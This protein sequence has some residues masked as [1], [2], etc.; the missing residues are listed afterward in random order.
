MN[1]DAPAR[2]AGFLAA[3]LPLGCAVAVE[4][5]VEGTVPVKPEVEHSLGRTALRRALAM[6]ADRG[7]CAV[8]ATAIPAAPNGA[9]ALPAGF[10]GSI[11]HS[12]GLAVAIAATAMAGTS[13]L[14][15]GVDVEVG[16]FRE[17]LLKFV[18]NDRELRALSPIRREQGVTARAAF[19]AKEAA[20]KAFSSNQ[21]WAV[22]RL[23][24][25]ELTEFCGSSSPSG[26]PFRA[27]AAGAGLQ[28][29]ICGTDMGWGAVAWA[30]LHNDLGSVGPV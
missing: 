21:P 2:A 9:P 14:S 16:D 17:D 27:V 19:S 18:F 13:L 20:F 11:S 5:K 26:R 6:V 4:G 1:S 23:G 8:N 30:V 7:N 29:E 3:T 10:I 24:Q 12:R 15:L 22:R 28:A 25:V